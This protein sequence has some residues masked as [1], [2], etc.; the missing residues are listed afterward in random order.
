[1]R[2][3]PVY[4]AGT[5]NWRLSQQMNSSSFENCVREKLLQ[6]LPANSVAVP[7]NAPYRSVQADKAPTKYSVK[8]EMI[9]W[10]QRHGVA[11]DSTVRKCPLYELILTKEPREKVFKI[12]QPLNARGHTVLRLSPYHCDLSP[13]ELV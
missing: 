4:K 11:C 13:I 9:S 5:G 3:K 10:L 6:H 2:G 12:D 7:D 8:S 1:V